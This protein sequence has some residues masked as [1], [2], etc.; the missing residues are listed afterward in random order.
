[1]NIIET[2][3]FKKIRVQYMDGTQKTI[4]KPSEIILSNRMLDV[5]NSID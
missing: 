3:K 1:M 4:I 2:E 5:F